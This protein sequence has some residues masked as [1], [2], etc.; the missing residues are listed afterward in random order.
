VEPRPYRSALADP[1]AKALYAYAEFRLLAVDERWDEAVSALDRAIAYDPESSYLR[2]NLARAYLHVNH[3]GEAVEQLLLLVEQTPED[4]AVRELLGEVYSFREDY[5]QAVEQF[6]EALR[7]DPASEP[8]QVQL[9]LALAQAGERAEAVAMLEDL[10]A[11]HPEAAL[12]QLSLA[13]FYSELGLQEEA[14]TAYRLLLEANPG[15]QPAV[16]EY[17]RLLEQQDPPAA[18]ALYAEALGFNPQ[19]LEVRRRLAQIYLDQQQTEAALEQLE[20]LLEVAPD[21]V[22]SVAQIG[23][24]NMELGNWRRAE[25]AFLELQES[26]K[27]RQR[28]SYYLALAQEELGKQ[29]EAIANLEQ[30]EE[31]SSLYPQ[32]SLQ[33]AYLYQRNER[34]DDALA[35]LEQLVAV[36]PQHVNAYY[37]LIA[38]LLEERGPDEALLVAQRA[39]EQNPESP[40]LTYQ[41]ALLQ[42][43]KN[44]RAEAVSW[45]ERVLELYPDHVEALNFLAYHQA[46][47]NIDLDLALTRVNRALEQQRAG[48]IVDTL[49]WIYFKME[50]YQDSLRVLTEAAQLMP[51]DPHIAD[52]L[53]DVYVALKM[54]GAAE[55]V[56]QRVRELDENFSGIDEKLSNLPGGGS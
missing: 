32:A 33:L 15:L 31:S 13:R 53:G 30:I 20:A 42:E 7:L 52:H 46:E 49:G 19:A 2:L 47:N 17:G 18:M 36:D 9:A 37:Y 55:K 38:L 40:D 44:M 4:V 22:Q 45:M 39:I 8:L 21:D 1:A 48:H 34:Q 43:R 23:L 12:A 50:R 41:Y 6:R 26:G 3:F 56:Y 35:R 11:V 54:W 24:L 14:L 16:L 51:D 27:Y 29:V 28:S 25:A 10:V 5:P